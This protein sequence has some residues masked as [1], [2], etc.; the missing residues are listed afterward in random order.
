MTSHY[1]LPLFFHLFQLLSRSYQTHPSVLVTFYLLLVA[2]AAYELLEKAV[3]ELTPSVRGFLAQH[4]VAAV[5][6]RHSRNVA[7]VVAKTGDVIIS[8][9]NRILDVEAKDEDGDGGESIATVFATLERASWGPTRRGS[10]ATA[11]K[12]LGGNHGGWK[13]FDSPYRYGY[14]RS[15][16]APR[17]RGWKQRLQEELA[18]QKDKSSPPSPASPDPPSPVKA[19]APLPPAPASTDNSHCTALQPASSAVDSTASKSSRLRGLV[20]H[21]TP[22]LVNLASILIAIRLLDLGSC[23]NLLAVALP[24]DLSLASFHSSTSATVGGV[25]LAAVGGTVWA[26]AL[27]VAE[28]QQMALGRGEADSI[29]SREALP[30]RAKHHGEEQ[31]SLRHPHPTQHHSAKRTRSSSS[32][33]SPVSRSGGLSLFSLLVLLSL[34]LFAPSS[35]SASPNKRRRLDGPPPIGAGSRAGW[36]TGVSTALALAGGAVAAAALGESALRAY[37]RSGG[38][39]AAATATSAAA[40]DAPTEAV[41]QPVPADAALA[42]RSSSPL[43]DL[44]DLSDLGD[45]ADGDEEIDSSDENEVAEVADGEAEETESEMSD[46]ESE[47]EEEEDAYE[48]SAEGESS[49]VD[50]YEFEGVSSEADECEVDSEDSEEASQ[51]ELDSDE[52]GE[53]EFDSDEAGLQGGD[54]NARAPSPP[55]PSALRRRSARRR[56][57][58]AQAGQMDESSV[59]GD[60]EDDAEAAAAAAAAAA[61]AAVRRGKRRATADSVE[62]ANLRDGQEARG[63]E[64]QA[65]AGEDSLAFPPRLRSLP[66]AQASPS[67]PSRTPCT[68]SICTRRDQ[69]VQPGD[70]YGVDVNLDAALARQLQDEEDERAATGPQAGEPSRS[71]A[72]SS[73]P[74]TSNYLAS[75]SASR[76]PPGPCDLSFLLPSSSPSRAASPLRALGVSDLSLTGGYDPATP[77]L[78]FR[79]K[80]KVAIP[81]GEVKVGDDLVGEHE[82]PVLVLRTARQRSTRVA[83]LTWRRY[84]STNQLKGRVEDSLCLDPEQLL[85]LQIQRTAA[86]KSDS[87]AQQYRQTTWLRRCEPAGPSQSATLDEMESGSGPMAVCARAVRRVTDMAARCACGNLRIVKPSLNSEAGT[88]ARVLSSP[89]GRALDPHVFLSGDTVLLTPNYIVS[90]PHTLP[91][92]HLGVRRPPLPVVVDAPFVP[93][94]FWTGPTLGEWLGDGKHNCTLISTSREDAPFLRQQLEEIRDRINA[95]LASGDEPVKVH[96]AITT[97]LGSARPTL[98]PGTRA[99]QDTLVLGIVGKLKGEHTYTPLLADLHRWNLFQNKEDGIPTEIMQGPLRL[100]QGLLA[101]LINAD[102]KLESSGYSYRFSQTK[103]GHEKLFFDTVKLAKSIGLQV[104]KIQYCSQPPPAG[105]VYKRTGKAE[106]VQLIVSFSGERV[107]DLQPYL[108][109]RKR[110]RP[111]EGAYEKNTRIFTTKILDKESEMIQVEVEGGRFQHETRTVLVDSAPH[112]DDETASVDSNDDSDSLSSDDDNPASPSSPSAAVFTSQFAPGYLASIGIPHPLPPPRHLDL[113]LEQAPRFRQT[114]EK[115]PQAGTGEYWRRRVEMWDAIDAGEVAGDSA[116]DYWEKR[117]EAREK[118][119]QRDAAGKGDKMEVDSA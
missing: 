76:L 58:V 56:R 99:L 72:A 94:T 50:E 19:S 88:L 90:P 39:A 102:G 38:S 92:N 82:Q 25:G 29:R 62:R 23:L 22:V 74:T 67:A 119:M 70:A 53:F 78:I 12:R 69:A 18:S 48:P 81:L 40:A 86:P 96:E 49:E 104:G 37:S 98:R 17:Q 106:H 83:K 117:R 27:N 91:R 59:E 43:S 89:R 54:M 20:F 64:R 32:R 13:W 85:D 11:L 65:E 63:D 113:L 4:S 33:S 6:G 3:D 61:R 71:T 60:T 115:D 79:D 109:P 114:F 73:Y 46:S 51:S 97:R 118:G 31:S 103:E 21:L 84:G 105:G 30:R 42:S 93:K 107:R 55:S 75:S 66:A 87:E 26:R 57:D 34:L 2:G 41:P 95:S 110:S 116:V 7:R 77:V 10:Y 111:L 68:C 45:D 14:F 8:F 80:K 112:D 36:T 1:L 15:P 108:L 28:Q 5:Y 47:S 44:S 100:R 52:A 9:G 24:A 35:T 16:S 101:G